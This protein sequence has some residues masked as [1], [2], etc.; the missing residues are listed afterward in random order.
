MTLL[1]KDT[2]RDYELGEV[3]AH[4]IAA[5]TRI[6]EG[7]AVGMDGEGYARSLQKGDRFLGFCEQQVAFEEG[8][9]HV[10]VKAAGKIT[11][12]LSNVTLG[13]VG[14]AVFADG[15]NSFTLTSDQNSFMGRVY[16]RE[17]EGVAIVAFDATLAS[18]DQT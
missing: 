2:P 9:R 17:S 18:L 7:A 16:R 3:N 13:D 4:L 5:G 10:R 14:K 8:N 1:T 6:Y 11:L 12:S 15:E